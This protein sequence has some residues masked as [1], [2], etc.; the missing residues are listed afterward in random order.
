MTS[1]MEQKNRAYRILRKLIDGTLSSGH[2]TEVKRW[3]VSDHDVADKEMAMHYV[4]DETTN[5][6]DENISE[7]LSIVHQKIRTFNTPVSHAFRFGRWLRYAAILLLPLITGVTAFWL[8]N[9][10]YENIEMTECYVPNGELRTVQL[11]DGSLVQIN[12]G[13]LLIYPQK[14]S[15]N[16]R[17][18]Y[19]SG[20]AHFSVSKD[21][22]KP[23]IVRT[24][25]LNVEVLGTKF[26][27]ESYPGSDCITTTLE[28][29]AVKV[30]REKTPH[31][32]IV[33][34]PN[35][36]VVYYS[37]KDR[38]TVSHVEAS[39]YTSWIHGELSFNNKSLNQI[40]AALERRY[41]VRFQVDEGIACSDLYTMKFKS[42]ETI[43]DA[44]HVFTLLI[45]DISYK[46]ERQTIR[47]YPKR[48]E[49][50]P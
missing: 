20:E 10:Y 9:S 29:G 46:K 13:T 2:R 31:Q 4:W 14:F 3:L 12:S 16:K 5:E 32:A 43:E 27:I 42:H 36:Q 45:G 50:K 18:V 28:E 11:P 35:E 15:G 25:P 41:N 49:V 1:E 38:F 30:Y 34:K 44:I 19:L 48:K 22:K 39:D 37:D 47:L 6:P 8:A 40:L 17:T 23:F 24:G 7:S 26:D 33:M 21:K